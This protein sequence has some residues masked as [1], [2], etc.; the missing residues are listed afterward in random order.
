MLQRVQSGG[1]GDEPVQARRALRTALGRF[2]TGVAVVTAES[3]DGHIHC[4]TV[5]SFTSLSLNPPL[6]MWALRTDSTR[7]DAMTRCGQFSVN[8]LAE[9]QVELARRHAVAPPQLAPVAEW[10]AHLEDCP[11]IAGAA[12]H[13]VCRPS[14]QLLQGDHTLLVGEVLHFA[15]NGRLPLLFMSGGFYSGR[16]LTAL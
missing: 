12:A 5:N 10:D 14:A 1:A 15:D 2:P 9:A 7:F 6:V 13:F 11:V 8:V 16:S 4:M 3:A